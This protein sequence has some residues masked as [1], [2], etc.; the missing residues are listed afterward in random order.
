V[1]GYYHDCLGRRFLLT[2]LLRKQWFLVVDMKSSRFI[3][4]IAMEY[5]CHK[6]PLICSICRN[7][8]TVLFLFMA[9]HLIFDK[10]NKTGASIGTG[11]SYPSR[12]DEFTPVY[13]CISGGWCSWCQI[14]CEC[15]NVFSSVLWD[16]LVISA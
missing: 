15:P 1:C 4:A 8:N 5:L 16:V 2:R 9:N 12:A 14:T 6:L 7:H 3:G 10:S 13:V 11:A